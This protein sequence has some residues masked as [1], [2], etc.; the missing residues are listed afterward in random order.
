MATLYLSCF[1][2]SRFN[3]SSFEPS[4]VN[5]PVF[6]FSTFQSFDLILGVVHASHLSASWIIMVP[7]NTCDQS[8]FITHILGEF[9][10]RFTRQRNI[11]RVGT[12]AKNAERCL[13]NI[14]TIDRYFQRFH[15]RCMC[16]ALPW[17]LRN[18]CYSSAHK[19]GAGVE[20]SCTLNA[21]AQ[22]K[23]LVETQQNLAVDIN[24]K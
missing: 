18:Y 14:S 10:S 11:I 16:C 24:N 8:Y 23:K 17:V 1:N 7:Y 5:R 3:L 9:R 19:S 21:T 20:L 13:W 6:N 15:F 12:K 4:P 2:R 22:R